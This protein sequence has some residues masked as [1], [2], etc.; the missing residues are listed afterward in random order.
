M[1]LAAAA[2][3]A[4]ALA[5]PSRSALRDEWDDYVAAFVSPDGRVIDAEAGAIT[6]SEG[7]AYGMLRAVWAD[8]PDTFARLR[9]WTRDNLQG[10][11]LAALP[12]WKW[13]ARPD[14]TWGVL[15]ANPASDADQLVAYAWLVAAERW[16]RPA[17]R[18]DARALLAR[19]WRDEVT[20]VGPY[21]VVL[22]GP[23]AREA[24]TVRLNPSYFLPF[25]WRSFAEV[26]PERPWAELIDDGYALLALTAGPAGLAPD[27]VWLD[28]ATAT[29]LPPNDPKLGDFGFEAFRVVWTLAA[30]AKW[31][32]E[33]RALGLLQAMD[34][35]PRTYRAEGRLPAVLSTGGEARVDWSYP[36]MY[37]A[38]LPG[39]AV[40]FP[41]EA[42]RLYRRELAPARAATG[43]GRPSDYY[44][45]NW[46]WFGLALW[47]GLAVPPERAG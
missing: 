45:R 41:A 13:G 39:W 2:V 6:T 33:E 36:G 44:A 11:D 37:G 9:T 1:T 25:A 32:R 35:L 8:D 3:V 28:A 14:G 5:A 20:E 19:I 26:D 30:E 24:A 34:V 7:Q 23:W 15:D 21:R 31:Y 29:V 42:R 38:L 12:A 4:T 18:T 46:I 17:L 10:G 43:W 40:A 27:W 47:S 16:D 22:P